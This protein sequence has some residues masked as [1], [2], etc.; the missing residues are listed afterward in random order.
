[1]KVAVTIRS[2]DDLSEL[3]PLIERL[4]GTAQLQVLE[5][6]RDIEYS[7]QFPVVALKDRGRHFG[8]EAID[9]LRELAE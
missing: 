4:R 3:L 5:A 1:M 2:G 7:Y 9:I 8:K 6:P